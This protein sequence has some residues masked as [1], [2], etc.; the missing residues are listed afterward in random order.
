M[1]L[2][3]SAALFACVLAFVAAGCGGAGGGGAAGATRNSATL[4]KFA[5]G[6]PKPAPEFAL[7]DA[8]GG[9]VRLA[10]LRGKVVLVTFLYTHCPDVCP[11]IA[12]NLNQALRQLGPE[13]ADVRVVAVSVDPRGDTRAAVATYRKEH[14]LLPQFRYLIGSKRQLAPVWRA[15]K[16]IAVSKGAD[17]VDHVAYTMLVDQR[18]ITRALYPV[19]TRP[20]P[21]V[22]DVRALL[23]S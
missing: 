19:E 4:G 1:P 12:A 9:R 3:R 21:I 8:A 5:V 2:V 14:H 13:R 15:Y 23:A 18:G 16:V 20:A 17:L 10:S 6:N 7:P 22:D 11:L